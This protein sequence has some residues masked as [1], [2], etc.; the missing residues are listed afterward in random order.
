[1]DFNNVTKGKAIPLGIIIIIITYLVSG[2]SSSIL[3]FIFFTGILIGI[4][5]HDDVLESLVASLIASFVATVIATIISLIMIYVSYG[6]MYVTYMLN[7]SLISI[8]FYIIAGAIGGI[9]G[10]YIF[11]E[12]QLK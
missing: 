7:S 4:M 1:M 10:Y 11:K 6:E 5:K 12:L 8:I 2:A 9:I 3:P